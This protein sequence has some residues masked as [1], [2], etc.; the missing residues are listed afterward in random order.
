MHA[1]L[2]MVHNNLQ[3]LKQLVS[4]LKGKNNDIYIHLDKKMGEVDYSA[5]EKEFPGHLFFTNRTNVIWGD[6][7]QINCEL[8]LLKMAVKTRKYD[9]L[10][11][12]SGSDLPL[13]TQADIYSFFEKNNGKEF[14]HY[15]TKELAG[16]NLEK[17]KYYFPLQSYIAGKRN[18]IY[19]LQ[20]VLIHIQRLAKINRRKNSS[21]VFAKG[22]NWFSITGNFAEFV[23]SQE[24]WISNTFRHTLCCDEIFLQTV[25][26]NSKFAKNLYYNGFDDNYIGNMRHIVWEGS[27]VNSHPHIFTK[28]D[29]YELKKSNM[30]FARKFSD[31]A[32]V[33]WIE[34]LSRR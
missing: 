34:E 29:I 26:I 13:K 1:Y 5:V 8:L 28:N 22:A 9:Y 33:L 6:Y 10:H 31:E 24:E 11:L 17:V 14:V 12:L 23:V 18:A 30:I 27:G 2:I 15:E 32:G 7:S 25:L 20:R 3:Q 21:M 16:P 4:V 19:Y